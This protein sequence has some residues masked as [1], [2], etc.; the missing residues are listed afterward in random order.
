MPWAAE[1]PSQAP[2]EN[3][4]RTLY[5][6]SERANHETKLN[7]HECGIGFSTKW[8]RVVSFDQPESG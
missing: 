1:Q 7:V 2:A 4:R 5:R 8:E 6:G 3:S